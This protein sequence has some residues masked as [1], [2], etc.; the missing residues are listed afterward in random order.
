MSYVCQSFRFV[1]EMRNL[2]QLVLTLIPVLVSATGTT[3]DCRRLQFGPNC[4][5]LHYLTFS[6]F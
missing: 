4:F 5:T 6:I 3:P 2:V 1:T